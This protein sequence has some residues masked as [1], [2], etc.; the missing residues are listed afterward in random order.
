MTMMKKHR[1]AP[2]GNK[3]AIGNSGGAPKGNKNAKDHGAPYG[4]RNAQTIGLY[5]NTGIFCEEPLQYEY[6][7]DEEKRVYDEI[8]EE[9]EGDRSSADNVFRVWKFES[10]IPYNVDFDVLFR[11]LQKS[12]AYTIFE[13]RKAAARKNKQLKEGAH[14]ARETRW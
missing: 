12:M 2:Y 6:L 3:N 9:A 1:G 10:N 4:N 13:L 8:L 11:A 7:T 14:G 5:A